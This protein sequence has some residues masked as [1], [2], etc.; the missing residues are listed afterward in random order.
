MSE[1][2]GE[3]AGELSLQ[4]KMWSVRNKFLSSDVYLEKT[5][6]PA[7]AQVCWQEWKTG[8]REVGVDE[9]QE[10]PEGEEETERL[11]LSGGLV[12][13]ILGNC[14]YGEW[15]AGA[16]AEFEVGSGGE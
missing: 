14:K 9:L 15:R 16:G 5:P 3:V 8:S 11:S 13:L 1:L 6:L 2:Q 12:L 10:E 4:E 7:G